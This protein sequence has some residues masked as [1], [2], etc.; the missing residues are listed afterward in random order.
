[1]KTPL[2]IKF[3]G[4]LALLAFVVGCETNAQFKE[5]NLTAAGFKAVPAKTAAQQ[6]HLKT[7]SAAKVTPVKRNGVQY[8]VYPDAANNVLYV[9]RQPQYDAYRRNKAALT[10]EREYQM[11]SQNAFIGNDAFLSSFDTW[12]PFEQ[13]PWN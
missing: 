5:S 9:G 4:V 12:G 7:L 3:L 2:P 11:A 1:M 13:L 10:S 6:A 8:Y